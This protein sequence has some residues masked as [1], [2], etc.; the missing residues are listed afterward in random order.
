MD[1]GVTRHHVFIVYKKIA[2]RS[3][4]QEDEDPIGPAKFFAPFFLGERKKEEDQYHSKK[5]VDGPV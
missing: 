1:I 4:G 5:E 3:Q 2:D